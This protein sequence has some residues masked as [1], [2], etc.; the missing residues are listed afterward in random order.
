MDQDNRSR[1]CLDAKH[2]GETP[3][4]WG[5]HREGV[6]RRGK[7]TLPC[8]GLDLLFLVLSASV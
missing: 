2:R 7:V 6:T 8:V 5:P 3:S 4:C 1:W